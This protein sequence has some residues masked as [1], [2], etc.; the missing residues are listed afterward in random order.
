MILGKQNHYM[1]LPLP[2]KI[3]ISKILHPRLC[4]HSIVHLQLSHRSYQQHHPS[5]HLTKS[6]L[7]LFL[8][9]PKTTA[10]IFP[11]FPLLPAT[12]SLSTARPPH[13]IKSITIHSRGNTKCFIKT[14]SQELRQ[15]SRWIIMPIHQRTFAKHSPFVTPTP[16][17]SMPSSSSKITKELLHPL[18]ISLT[19]PKLL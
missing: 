9:L 2:F 11:V 16:P 12:L 1:R 3:A 6:L 4:P 13:T 17:M 8:F 15:Q 10:A 18:V 19:S 5:T 14:L 7:H